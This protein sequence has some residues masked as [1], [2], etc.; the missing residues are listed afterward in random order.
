MA[1]P[2]C[3]PD[4]ESMK[5]WNRGFSRCPAVKHSP[6]GWS[7]L[8]LGCLGA[9]ARLVI[10]LCTYR[11]NT[12]QAME[13]QPVLGVSRNDVAWAP[14]SC[15]VD[16]HYDV[17]HLDGDPVAVRFSASGDGGV[18]WED[19]GYRFTG[20]IGPV[21]MPGPNKVVRWRFPPWWIGRPSAP[22]RF[23]I[24]AG[25]TDVDVYGA[26]RYESVSI[27]S[28]RFQRQPPPSSPAGLPRNGFLWN[29][30]ILMTL[31]TN[32]IPLRVRVG[33]PSGNGALD[34]HLCEF[35]RREW[36]GKPDA[37]RAY[38]RFRRK[39]QFF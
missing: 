29:G 18:S 9:V 5:M 7:R 17:W 19:I 25:E 22:V 32:G 31:E 26:N 16:L 15:D 6:Q 34:R 35:I 23:R 3:A 1:V 24:T 13:E 8:L 4:L 12:L 30:E 11:V 38:L 28:P 36:I 20:D 39:I 14:G 21:V 2:T 33:A 27:P 37:A 10:L